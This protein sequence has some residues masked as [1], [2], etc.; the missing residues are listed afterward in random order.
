[1]RWSPFTSIKR[2]AAANA[3]AANRSRSARW[4]LTAS[5]MVSRGIGSCMGA[6]TV[7]LKSLTS[8]YRSSL[9]VLLATKPDPLRWRATGKLKIVGSLVSDRE[10]ERHGIL[11]YSQRLERPPGD[12]N[13]LLIAKQDERHGDFIFVEADRGRLSLR[14]YGDLD[15]LNIGE[16]QPLDTAG[17]QRSTRLF[18]IVDNGLDHFGITKAD[19]ARLVGQSTL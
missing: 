10:M 14:L 16:A 5:V 18:A 3:N 19:N 7:I 15:L 13:A 12:G 6:V 9:S 8:V 11:R 4:S 2:S 17:R 1:M